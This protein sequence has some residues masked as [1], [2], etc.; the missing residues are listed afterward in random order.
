[1]PLKSA[2]RLGGNI[3][4]IAYYVLSKRRKITID[5]LLTAFPEKK[6]TDIEIIA[7]KVFINLG[8]SFTELL[9]FPN[10]NVKNLSELINYKNL[11][12]MIDRHKEGKGVIMLSGHFGNWELIALATGFLSKIP[13]TIIV[14]TQT[15]IHVDNIIN[16][17]RTIFGNK[18]VPMEISVREILSTLQT[19]GIVAMVADQSATKESVFVDF[20]GRKVATFQGPA[21]F[22]IRTGAPLQMG[23]ITRNSDGNYDVVIEEIDTSD[24]KEYNQENIYELTRRHTN[25]LEK[26]IRLYPDHWMWTHRRWKNII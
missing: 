14:K 16:R 1:M 6:R 11:E 24:L 23:I 12:K 4:V 21:A 7:K 22:A 25:V 17:N 15:N 20:F 5:N 2:Q 18:V 26:Y 13:F 3:G 19:G 8:I 9:W 10:F